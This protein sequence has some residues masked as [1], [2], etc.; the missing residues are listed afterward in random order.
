MPE[1]KTIWTQAAALAEKTP[2]TRNRYVD[3]LRAAS[4][5]VVMSGHWLVAA[6]FLD[7]ENLI[8]PDILSI[9][10]WTQWLTWLMQVM[11]I[12]FIVGGFANA[13]SWRSAQ[14]KDTPY[15]EWLAARLRRLIT[16]VLPVLVFWGILGVI[17][18]VLRADV[19]V[20]QAASRFALLPAWFLVVYIVVVS[21]VPLTYKAWET[22]QLGS[23]WALVAGAVVIDLI[24]FAGGFRWVGWF[25]YFFVWLAVHQIGYAWQ[26]QRFVRPL[27]WA[28]GGLFV[29]GALVNFGPYP[30]SMVSVQGDEISNT[31]PP[32]LTMLALGV[33]QG[34]VLLALEKWMRNWLD[35]ARVWTATILINGMIMTLFL[36]HVT[37]LVMV[38]GVSLLFGGVGL[39]IV[40]GTSAWWLTRPIW[41]LILGTVLLLVTPIFVRYE[42]IR[43][44]E[45][46]DSPALWRS[47]LGAFLFCY[48]LA[49][50]T[51][52][53]IT[54]DHGF[55]VRIVELT[56]PFI[57]AWL[58]G[59]FQRDR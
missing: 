36:W 25:N 48:G 33:F 23:F 11:P 27:L 12:F 28:L 56:L 20:L 31:L 9:A 34:G 18:T 29:L 30:V 59:I 15:S 53:G 4:I 21:L 37:V 58:I 10:P 32:N 57:G 14:R 19:V 26:A 55:G 24:A 51:L 50:L 8:L 52:K 45:D 17:A 13:T 35:S 22:M 1:K 16:P 43:P 3:F 47:L 5:L 46:T 38:S 42:R 44:L 2:P 7:G 39:R 40:P 41:I 6:P 49:L 54:A